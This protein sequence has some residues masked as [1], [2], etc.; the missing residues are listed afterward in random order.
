[1]FRTAKWSLA[2]SLLIAL[3]GP[4]SHAGT[5][6]A[7]SCNQ[8]D[9]NA[10]INGPT[11]TA[12]DGDTINIPAGSCTWTTGVT[13]PVGIGIT[14]MGTGTPNTG[15]STTG[16]GTPSTTITSNIGGN[17]FVMHPHFGNSTARISTMKVTWGTSTTPL[18]MFVGSCTSSGCPNMRVDNVNIPT[19]GAC[20]VPD[21]SA[22]I[23]AN[24]FGVLDHNTVGDV[25]SSCNGIDFVNVNHA[26]WLGV[27]QYGDNSWLSADSFGTSQALYLE[28]NQ[29]NF[30]FGT[31]TDGADAYQDVGGGR[32][33]CRFNNFN[34]VTTASACTNH[35]TETTGRPRGGRQAEDYKNTLLCTNTS[36]GCSNGFGFRSGVGRV[37]GNTFS[38]S[39]GS[40]Y[41][42]Y[43]SGTNERRYRPVHWGYC[44]GI[45]P[46]DTNDG[47][48]IVYTGTISSVGTG[49]ISVSGTPWTPGAF[50]FSTSSPGAVYYAVFDQTTDEFAG[51]ASNTS[52]QLT[53]STWKQSS[54]G[55]SFSGS[56]FVVGDTILIMTSTLYAAGT[57][58]GSSGSSTVT[59]STKTWTTNQWAP[60][61]SAYSVLD[62]S[63]AASLEFQIGSNTSNTLTAYQESQSG[64][65]WTNGD[66][67]VILRASKCLDQPAAFGGNLLSGAIPAP[68]ATPQ[69]IDPTYEFADTGTVPNNGVVGAD[70]LSIVP[71]II[72]EVSQS[73]QTSPTSPF[74]GTQ[75]TGYGTL[76]NRPTTCTPRVGYWATDQG[77]WNQSGSG[78]QGQLYVCT[79]TNTWTLNYMPYTY[80]HPLIAGGT[81]GTIVNPPTNL[82]AIVQ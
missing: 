55:G 34:G 66:A 2:L 49:T 50:N 13:V 43:T 81:T 36:Q 18:F 4:A 74:N 28:N 46:W 53:L 42:H 76:A 6:T 22:I 33:V 7:A 56:S 60:I 29:F 17:V 40:W 1:V 45:D 16:A 79:A 70:D 24:M 12:V 73:Q 68:P 82:G 35:G 41:N 77:N 27:G 78:G 32:F 67:Y 10:V 15:P 21:A 61:G 72:G 30:S 38:I 69:T 20:S 5:Y 39:A 63:N 8:S 71:N 80:P 19:A 47:G 51:I 57:H 62:V 3:C 75:G 26:V 59:D 64:A 65:T 44:D 58:T 52:S 31:D 11:H 37:W 54:A 48:S 14:I 9:V 25:Q 23:A